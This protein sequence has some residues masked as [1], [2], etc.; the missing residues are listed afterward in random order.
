MGEPGALRER[1]ARLAACRAAIAH[2]AEEPVA[3]AAA[4]PARAAWR[5][6]AMGRLT[7]DYRKRID[8]LEDPVETQAP[9]FRPRHPRQ[10]ASAA[11]ATC[12]SWSCACRRCVE[13]SALYAERQAQHINDESLRALVA[14][15]DLAEV[16]LRKRLAVA[17]SRTGQAERAEDRNT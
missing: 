3:D 7:Q 5:Q 14:E 4:D 16:S 8:L 15:I 1:L 13:R 10:C 9:S 12:W 17:R 6:E 11:C 2:L